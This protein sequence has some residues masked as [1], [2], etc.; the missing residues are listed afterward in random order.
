ML[1]GALVLFGALLACFSF[2][3]AQR[4]WV[5]V[6]ESTAA[7]N[8][9]VDG[10]VWLHGGPIGLRNG[11]EWFST[12]DANLKLTKISSGW[13]EDDI[14]DYKLVTAVYSANDVE[15]LHAIFKSYTSAN[16]AIF[17]QYFPIGANNTSAGSTF[18]LAS[19]FPSFTDTVT[20]FNYLTFQRKFARPHIGKWDNPQFEGGEF[21]GM[22]MVLYDSTLRSLVISP[23][24][25]YMASGQ[26]MSSHFGDIFGCGLEGKIEQIPVEFHHT[27]IMVFGTAITSAMSQWGQYLLQA[28]GKPLT[29]QQDMTT[30]KLGYYTDNGAFYYYNTEPSKNYED[31]MIDI[32][33]YQKGI[34][35]HKNY[36]LDSWWYTRGENNGVKLWE[37]R[38]DIFP[39][40]MAFLNSKMDNIPFVLHNRYF[41]TDNDY[42]AMNFSFAVEDYMAL[43]LE[44]D[45]FAYIMGKA[46]TWGMTVY[47]QD[48]LVTTY[49]KMEI[50]R[51]NVYTSRQWL[52]NMGNAASN[53]NVFIQYCMPLPNFLLE[54]TEIFPVTQARASEDYNPGNKNW[55]ILHSSMLIW[56]LGM[57]P[58]KDNFWSTTEQLGCPYILCREPNPVI[59]TLS[60]ALAGGPLAIGDKIEFTDSELVMH[61]CM[62]DGT[63]IKADRPAIPLDKAFLQFDGIDPSV[64]HLGETRATVSG[65]TWHYIFCTELPYDMDI[66]PEDLGMDNSGIVVDYFDDPNSPSE[67]NSTLPLHLATQGT[68]APYTIVPYKYYVIAP[69]LSSGWVFIGDM[70][71][72]ITV[73]STRIQ[74]VDYD[75]AGQVYVEAIGSPEETITLS[76]YSP[77]GASVSG[78][79]AIAASGKTYCGVLCTCASVCTCAQA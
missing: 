7:F 30:Q 79:C 34:L 55:Q 58:F 14:G 74:L 45:L 32:Y 68:V 66:Y 44:Q 67:F 61:T 24:S 33:N 5:D 59:Q 52:Q 38:E 8:V 29:F 72:F 65:M 9:E 76:F 41:S 51:N 54:S 71:K 3:A 43:P 27:T 48:W 11:G 46:V 49:T 6:D 56:A 53:L 13:S 4:L 10:E 63:L 23:F 36:Q 40:G 28:T 64:V 18:E 21:G 42:I 2:T 1:R 62:L 31:T 70:S 22:P 73:S 78:S 75:T 37:P 57:V 35:P 77:T 20:N 39:D 47:E 19:C 50:T 60:S 17:E 16:V 25:N 26:T 15:I 12:Q 69:D